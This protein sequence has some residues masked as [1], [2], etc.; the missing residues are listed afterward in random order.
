MAGAATLIIRSEAPLRKAG[1]LRTKAA[2][3]T[4]VM[5]AIRII[6]VRFYVCCR[7]KTRSKR[8]DGG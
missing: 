4:A 8:F 2:T 5:G 6:V 3:L 1:E 7:P